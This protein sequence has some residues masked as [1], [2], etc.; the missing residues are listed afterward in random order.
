MAINNVYDIYNS[1]FDSDN[2]IVQVIMAD[3][4]STLATNITNNISVFDYDLSPNTGTLPMIQ[5]NRIVDRILC[6]LR[7]Q[8]IRARIKA[9]SIPNPDTDTP[10]YSTPYF[11]NLSTNLSLI[12]ITWY[13]R[14]AQEFMKTYC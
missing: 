4:M 7:S 10:P 11:N 3:I 13:T 12:T 2:V 8:G 14:N 5:Q 1:T 9:T 6:I